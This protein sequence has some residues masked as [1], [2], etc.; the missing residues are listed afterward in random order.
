MLQETP[1]EQDR[2]TGRLLGIRVANL[3]RKLKN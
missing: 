2:E 3:A 1:N